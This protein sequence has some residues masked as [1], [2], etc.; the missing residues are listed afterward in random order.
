MYNCNQNRNVGISSYLAFFCLSSRSLS[1]LRLA[2]RSETSF[3]GVSRL[4][5]LK[6]SRSTF[7]S[8]RLVGVAR[9]E[10]VPLVVV[11]VGKALVGEEK[12]KRTVDLEPL[13]GESACDESGAGVGAF[14]VKLSH[15]SKGVW[16]LIREGRGRVVGG[17]AGF[18]KVGGS[19][20]RGLEAG[21]LGAK[22]DVALLGR[23]G[24]SRSSLS[25]MVVA[26]GF[27]RAL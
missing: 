25:E 2:S 1:A 13:T 5:R 10:L 11:G 6:S 14:G 19:S 18:V 17:S 4:V 24:A 12:P 15:I 20:V 8:V 22:F 23:F 26:C 21:T 7:F 3:D 16:R 9:R 27:A